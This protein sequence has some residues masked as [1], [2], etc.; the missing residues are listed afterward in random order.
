MSEESVARRQVAEQAAC[1]REKLQAGGWWHSIDLGDR[2]T[3]G[4][5]T[6]PHLRRYWPDMGFPDDLRGKRLLDIGCWDGFF[7]FEAERH[8]AE[9][10]AV[11][12]WR[13]PNFF[14]AREALGSKV[15]FREMSVYEVSRRKLGTFD[16][17]LF[18]GVLYHL[19]HPLL[20]LERVCEVTKE[21]SIIESHIIDDFIACEP[22]L[23]EFYEGSELAGQDDNWWGPSYDCLTRM[24]RAAGFV[25]TEKF[26]RAP[27]R[28]TIRAWRDWEPGVLEHEPSLH[29]AE[30]VNPATWQPE[31]PI[32][33]RR[34]FLGTYAS[35][36][37]E[38]TTVETLRIHV[39]TFG[40][41]PTFVGGSEFEGLQQINAR[42]PPGLKPGT[43]ILWIEERGR[44]S[45]PVE[46]QLTEGT[47]W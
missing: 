13:P 1:N 3:P 2:V 25:R 5:N 42:V 31:I 10:L 23:M 6:L 33:G 9:V 45:N 17:V 35:G 16:I 38:D 46:F 22:P 21:Q 27:A 37:P 8:G 15:E 47:E 26:R 20:G 32:S 14:K 39:G 4:A 41:I 18:L 44:R 24:T 12:C 34:A 28:V 29:I 11:D 19:R 43:A 7:S 40:A 30:V 36:L